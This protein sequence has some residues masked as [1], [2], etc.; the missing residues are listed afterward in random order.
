MYTSGISSWL[1]FD[2]SVVRGLSYYTGVVFEGFDRSGQLRAI[3]GGG[4]CV[5]T[6]LSVCYIV[7]IYCMFDCLCCTHFYT[8]FAHIL[9]HTCRYDKLIDTMSAGESSIPAVG[10]G[11]GDAVIVELLKMKNLLPDLSDNKIDVLVYYMAAVTPKNDLSD[12]TSAS[13]SVA[14]TEKLNLLLQ[15]KAIVA[16][17]NLRNVGLVTELVM[18]EKKA[19]WAFQRADKLKAGK[20]IYLCVLSLLY[21]H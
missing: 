7:F 8:L 4:R 2:P 17:R 16:A 3:C 19:K 5:Y 13:T 12:A 18:E 9:I 11:F 20:C 10:F 14:E 15:T 21:C 6:D 1:Q